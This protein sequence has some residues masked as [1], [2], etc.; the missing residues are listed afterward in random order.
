MRLKAEKFFSESNLSW[1]CDVI[2]AIA[3]KAMMFMLKFVPCL[4]CSFFRFASRVYFSSSLSVLK[5]VIVPSP[6]LFMLW[7]LIWGSSSLY[8]ISA[9]KDLRKPRRTAILSTWLSSSI[10]C[11]VCICGIFLEHC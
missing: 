8:L 9:S 6:M 11:C 4:T 7:I 1:G 5:C 2:M 10:V 3:S